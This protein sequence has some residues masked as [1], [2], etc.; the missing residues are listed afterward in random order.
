M[1]R[2]TPRHMAPK[3]RPR[4]AQCVS[5][6]CARRVETGTRYCS[7][8]GPTYVEYWNDRKEVRA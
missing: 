7:Q 1:T 8:C 6:D 5:K 3:R 4:R 2:P